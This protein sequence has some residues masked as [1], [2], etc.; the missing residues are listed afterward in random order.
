[1]SVAIEQEGQAQISARGQ[2]SGPNPAA[3]GSE[4]P[5][6]RAREGERNHQVFANRVATKAGAHTKRVTGGGRLFTGSHCRLWD[7]EAKPGYRG[8]KAKDRNE[9]PQHGE[10]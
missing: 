2:K 3:I 6:A 10:R 5:Y 8:H 4:Q 9:L 7:D 1:V